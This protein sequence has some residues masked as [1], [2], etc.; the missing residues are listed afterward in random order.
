MDEYTTSLAL[1]ILRY[2]DPEEGYILILNW[3]PRDSKFDH[4]DA[5]VMEKHEFATVSPTWRGAYENAE[6]AIT[7]ISDTR[8]FYH[9]KALLRGLTPIPL[10]NLKVCVEEWHAG[11]SGPALGAH[12]TWTFIGSSEVNVEVSE[13][14][15]VFRGMHDNR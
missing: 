6:I 9:K 14:Q 15:G 2:K 8:K 1:R 13:R 12:Y 4:H 11:F 5:C 10:D 3:N 7:N